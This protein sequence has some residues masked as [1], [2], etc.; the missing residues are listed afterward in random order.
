MKKIYLIAFTILSSA[1]GFSQS[2]AGFHYSLS[3]PQGEMKENIKL[4]HSLNA[5]YQY[6]LP[7]KMKWLAFGTD[8]SLGTYAQLYKQQ[9]LRFPDGTGTTTMV[10]YSSNV[11]S[12]A[13]LTRLNLFQEATIN[14]YINFKGGYTL[15]YSNVSVEDP[16]DPDECRVLERKNILSDNT[17]F[18]TYG[19]GVQIKLS[20]H[21]KN[22]NDNNKC[23]LDISINKVR[24][25]KL[26]YINT[27][28]IESH[29]HTD[30]NTPAPPDGKGQ[31]LNV[32]FVNVNT[33]AIHEHQVAE[34]YNSPLR[35]LDIKVGLLF[36]LW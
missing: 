11:F 19:G 26:D 4:T 12:G 8:L 20:S 14:P 21:A 24:G 1:I 31:P 7:G 28:H 17:F 15:F 33:Q 2:R 3:L 23:L 30:P 27:R 34:I 29:V 6:V 35:M 36:E 13:L 5:A 32:R 9:D 16:E 10:N 22:K 18:F 25:G